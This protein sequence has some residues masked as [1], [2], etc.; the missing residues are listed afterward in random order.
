MTWYRVG[1]AG[2]PGSLKTD[3]D[4]VLNKKFGTSTTYP[5]NTWPDNVNLLGPLPEKTASGAIANF[6]D[7]ADGVPLKNWLV[8]LPASLDGYSEVNGT[9]SG[10]NLFDGELENGWIG[11]DG[12]ESPTAGRTRS[13]NYLKCKGDTSYY[14]TC[15]DSWRVVFYDSTKT[16]ISYVGTY[17]SNRAITSPSNAV[18]FRFA[19]IAE[20]S[21]GVGLNYPS[22]ETSAQTP[23]APTQYTASLGRTI[24]GGQADIVNGIGTDDSIL[25]ELDGSEDESYSG[26]GNRIAFT[27]YSSVIVKN[28]A[29]N[30]TIKGDY[31]DSFPQV[32]NDNTYSGVLGF[33]VSANDSTYIYFSDGTGSM[34]A[35]AFRAWLQNN[36]IK[37]ILKIRNST[38][39]TFTPITADTELGVNNFWADEGDSAVTYR[40]DISLALQALGG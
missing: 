2:I 30:T 26:S 5:P 10:A 32:T 38:D 12:S 6:S 31:C 34:T 25:I 11:N 22:T 4:A 7:G 33:S 36:P 14:V 1:P 40:A 28:T 15:S 29:N 24:Y 35:E 19:I 9:K 37:M 20:T 13:K 39:F 3:M 27:S 18:Y 23:K 8:T 21:S 16:F 17:S